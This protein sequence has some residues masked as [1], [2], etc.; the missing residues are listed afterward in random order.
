MNRSKTLLILII[1]LL[2]FSPDGFAQENHGRPK[3]GLTLAGGGAKG[4]AHIGILEAIDSAGLRIDAITGT[5]MGSIIGA[6]Y[7][8]GY[9]GEAIEKIARK[10][11]WDLMFSTTPKLNSISIERKDEYNKYAL[12]VPFENGQ[13]KIRKGFIEG[14]ELWLKFAELFEPVYYIN[15]FSKFPIPFKCIGTDLE[16]G[17]P[18]VM[19]HG[20]ITTCVRASMAIPSVFTPVLY[21]GKTLVDG[22]LVNNF[23]VLEV[24]EMGADIV[25]G[26]NLS[27]GLE[28]AENLKS[29]VDILLQICSYKDAEHF[30]KH[31]EACDIYILPE[32]KN[33]SSASFG[34]SNSLID[35][36]KETAKK[37]Y[38]VFK[39]LADSL[40]AIYPQEP[41][42]R[43]RLPVNNPVIIN[44]YTVEGLKFTRD[45]F[46]FG[47]LNLDH[48]EVYSSKKVAESVRRVYSSLYYNKINFGFSQPESGKTVINFKVEENPLTSVKVGINFSTFSSLGLKFNITSYDLLFKESHALATV[49]VSQNPRLYLEYYKFLGQSR[50]Y[51]VNVSYYNENMDYPVYEN[52]RLRD[53][54]K[55]RY[56][57][58]D[59]RL[60]HNISKNMYLGIGQ[61][62]INSRIRKPESAELTYDRTNSYL[63]SYMSY[64]LNSTDKKYFTTKGWKIGA[65][66][67]YIYN[68]APD[69]TSGNNN[70]TITNLQPG[71]GYNN[72]VRLFIKAEHYN[73]L[74]SKL[75]FSQNATLAYIIDNN[76]HVTNLFLVGGI[77][78]IMSN[79][80]PFAGLGE[81]EIKTGSIAAIKFSLQ[82]ALSKNN[83]L[84]GRINAALYDFQNTERSITAANNLITGYGLTYGY[85]SA[86]GPIE[87]SAMYC[88]QDGIVRYSMNLGFSF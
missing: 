29:P 70:D 15:D 33:Y 22:G 28:K 46:F 30:Q 69:L 50:T 5:S 53:N 61:Q 41:Y 72:Y 48:N 17:N 4:L 1:L 2:P 9:S 21:E 10:L 42:V 59:L 54:L 16:T 18:V 52:F 34:A 57:E 35:I 44:D 86:I 68:Q 66:A 26:V 47:L 73:A 77:S 36:G 82:Y 49:N 23:P 8:A 71:T 75:I 43:N 11:D 39:K 80:I 83:Y 55:N 67:G 6:L 60:Q 88:D 32:L 58:L 84:T 25:I 74:N 7:A 79:Q 64:V 40:N 56:S 14:Q 63:K 78:D 62:F 85:D 13:F 3:I 51:G 65:E 19:D 45:K 20:D 87:F 37:Y 76:P 81:S 27:K 12:E 24:K 31:R 38:P